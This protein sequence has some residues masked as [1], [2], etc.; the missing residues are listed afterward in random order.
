M[1]HHSQL[2]HH[3]RNSLEKRLSRRY[4][5]WQPSFHYG[6]TLLVEEQRQSPKKKVQVCGQTK[7]NHSLNVINIFYKIKNK[8]FVGLRDRNLWIDVVWR[9]A[10]FCYMDHLYLFYQV[11]FAAVIRV[12]THWSS[13]L[14]AVHLSSAFL[15]SNWR[16]RSRLP[17]SGNLV[18][19][20]KCNE[21]YHW[22]A[23]NKYMHVIGS[24]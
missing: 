10:D 15:S 23:A 8:Y 1:L 21:K 9:V 20:G 2:K 13:P 7:T 24:Q 3:Y 17:Y 12:V 14:T 16:I 5:T 22:Q 19:G 6:K 18:F 11:S 4:L